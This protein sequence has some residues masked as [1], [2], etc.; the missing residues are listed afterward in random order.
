M[1]RYDKNGPLALGFN[2][3]FLVFILAPL[4]VVVPGL[5]LSAVQLSLDLFGGGEGD[6]AEFDPAR[7]RRSSIDPR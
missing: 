3:I 7:R 6:R 1:R 5:V 2:F 4:V